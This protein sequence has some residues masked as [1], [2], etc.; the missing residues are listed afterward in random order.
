MSAPPT[1]RERLLARVDAL[2]H[3]PGVYLFKD[4]AG[5]VLYVG[6]AKSLRDRVRGYFRE[7]GDGRLFVRFVERRVADV[8][9]LVTRSEKEAFL[10]ENNLIKQHKP[11]FNIRLKDDK[12]FLHL[13]VDGKHPFPA[14][15]P[16]RRPRKDGARYL[17][18]YSSA[19]AIRTTLRLLRTVFPLRNC[20]DAEFANRTRPC[21][22]H[23]IHLCGAPCVGLVTREQYAEMLEGA[24]RVLQGRTDELAARLER[25]M[26]EA[27]A[28]LEYERASVLRDRI[29][30]LRTSTE[31]Q[32]VEQSRFLDRDAIGFHRR[33]P[34]VEL[35]VLEFRGG[36]LLSSRPWS[37][38]TDLP[39]DEALAQ[40]LGAWYA[41]GRPIPDEVAQPFEAY[42][43][44][45]LQEV[46][47]ERRGRP[48]R[49]W[50]PRGGDAA[51]AIE[52]ANR[53]AELALKTARDQESVELRIL[54][55]VKRRLGL[56]AAPRTVECID[57]SHLQGGQ[58]VAAL[59][60]FADGKPDKARYRRYR[61]RGAAGNDDFAAMREVIERRFRPRRSSSPSQGVA[62]APTPD[63]LMIDGG[64]PQ[65]NAVTERLRALCVEV[66]VAGIVKAK[67]R[68]RGLALRAD[69]V[70][71][72]VLPE[73][74]EPVAL[75][76]EDE[77]CF[78]L[79]RVRDEAHRFAISYHRRLRS[80][81]ALSSELAGIDGLGAKRVRSL[82]RGL[83]GLSGV[84]AASQEQLSAV[85]GI[86]PALA[87]RI[88][89]RLHA[90]AGPS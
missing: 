61:L 80:R 14:I 70:D 16:M 39:D 22:Q 86:G 68:G 74:A 32:A 24:L 57:V 21:L 52:M 5:E 90:A 75:P 40:F 64:R 87:R 51:R 78:L 81:A 84:K 36:K 17:G 19:R 8:E 41:G 83:G 38:S 63:L 53:N 50:Q 82:L 72:V 2:P 56:S 4:A 73:R 71:H 58:A 66:A 44:D 69:E 67:R 10:L 45:T 34:R 46:L 54:E 89:E 6:K 59:V 1:S 18:P 88:W 76:P 25:E 37:L 48:V 29:A 33:G 30:F 23:Q 65:V 28:R 55:D 20:S 26:G 7:R 49:V 27:S 13:R 35:C 42:A 43:A 85:P 9:V 31:A 60:T 47:S 3:G 12:S 62:P 11:R 77:A 15:V 79:Q